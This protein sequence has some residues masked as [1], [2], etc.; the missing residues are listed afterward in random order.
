M[1]LDQLTS[2]LD[3]L[4]AYEPGPYPVVS[5][6]LDLQPNQ[7]GRDDFDRFL[8]KE[9]SARIATYAKSG[10]E[11]ESLN[12]DAERIRSYVAS[13][14]PSANGLAIFA[15]SGAD[16]FE[17]I[18]LAAPIGA[19]TLHISREPHLY[20][21]ARLRDEYPTYAVLVANTHSARILVF[22]ANA[23]RGTEE[24]EGTK[25]K[26]HKMG[27]WSQAR[28]QRHTENYHLK[29]A[30]EVIDTLAR[31]V[32]HERIRSIVIA[33][34]EVIVPVLRE[35]MPKELADRIVDVIRLDSR[36]GEREILEKTIAAMREQDAET[37]RA[38]VDALLDA[39]RA[40]GLA[41]VGVEDARR[42]LEI[43]QVD[44]LLI[45]AAPETIDPG[46]K[47][48]GGE[49]GGRSTAERTADDLI[50]KA[51]QTAAKVR[52]IEDASLLASVGGVGAF[53]RFAA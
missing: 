29:H 17:A 38:R 8:R 12:E 34:D 25:T 30:K 18:P 40:S 5:L 46:A 45:T 11:R 19:H 7:H 32:A 42:A 36:A 16:L 14:D 47:A 31:I 9:L 41:V 2:R 22:A 28:Y 35:Q 37:D 20:P 43:G 52:F 50:V 33:G 15:C 24:V 48:P 23:L 51:R 1:A 44:E 3:R 6:Y 39:Y 49:E 53:L 27:G 21:L 10:P 26:R 13:V 4:A